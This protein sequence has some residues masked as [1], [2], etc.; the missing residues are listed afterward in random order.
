MAIEL[1][2][3]SV[4]EVLGKYI[5]WSKIPSEVLYNACQRGT[6]V[7]SYCEALARGNYM[8]DPAESIRGYV[9]SFARWFDQNVVDVLLVEKRLTNKELGLTGRPDFVFKIKSG[10]LV[11]TD[12]KTPVPISKTWRFQLSA[13]DYL[14]RD[15]GV[16]HVDACM[17]LRLKRD[18]S[19][20]MG[21]R[22]E[23]GRVD[24]WNSFLSAL[25]AHRAIMAAQNTHPRRL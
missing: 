2:M 15:V 18:G 17:S 14:L 1:V 16:I 25:N 24:A 8:M 11:L 19:A 20:A 22:Y 21:Q 9:R 13:Y 6:A 4:T 3:Y 10:E 12:I 7:H 5:D 23:S